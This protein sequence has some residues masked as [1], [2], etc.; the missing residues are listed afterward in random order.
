MKL[1]EQLR[2]LAN[3]SGISSCAISI[4]RA[5]DTPPGVV[6]LFQSKRRLRFVHSLDK[7][8]VENFKAIHL[9]F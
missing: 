4:L 2:Q 6:G 1:F 9:F 7:F 8:L 3:K 5:E